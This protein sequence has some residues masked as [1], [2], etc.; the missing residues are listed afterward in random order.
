MKSTTPGPGLA[1]KMKTEPP[2]ATTGGIS[3][4]LVGTNPQRNLQGPNVRTARILGLVWPDLHGFA[5]LAS[6]CFLQLP[7]HGKLH[8]P[9][10]E[11]I[12]R[13]HQLWIAPRKLMTGGLANHTRLRRSQSSGNPMCCPADSWKRGKDLKIP[14]PRKR[15]SQTF[16]TKHL[17]I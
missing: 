6:S 7:L 4:Q 8:T 3:D 10:D 2:K 11:S 9:H 14:A 17:H 13:V 1:A 16:R 15:R 12:H 5:G